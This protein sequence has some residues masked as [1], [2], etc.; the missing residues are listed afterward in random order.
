MPLKCVCLEI[1]C[2][3][4][5]AFDAGGSSFRSFFV[6]MEQFLFDHAWFKCQSDAVRGC[7]VPL[8]IRRTRDGF[9][10][11]PGLILKRRSGVI[12]RISPFFRKKKIKVMTSQWET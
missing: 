4:L 12:S 9:F 7:R 6:A 11:V 10:L 2:L 8:I 3:G 5:L 1:Y